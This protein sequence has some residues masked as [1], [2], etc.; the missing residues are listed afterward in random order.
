MNYP[1]FYDDV[2]SIELYDPLSEVLGTF[3]DGNYS[4]SYKEVVKSAGHSCPTVAGAYIV[5]LVGLKA[6]YKDQ[7]A[8]RG[9]IEVRF[10][11]SLE[12]G[13]A[14]VIANVITQIT[15]ATDKS[16]FKGLGGIF[17]RH[18]LMHFSS[19]IASS[20]RFTRKDTQE[21]VDLFYNPKEILPNPKM[22][23]LMQ[24]ILQQSASTQEKQEFGALWQE[25][26]ENIFFNIEKVVRVEK[27]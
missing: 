13:V 23:P 25:R 19:D 11:E 27:V 20:V 17:A 18:S 5:T 21:S 4:I 15:G 10:K 22:Q 9:E 26:V 12:E 6:L 2:E 3:E 8:V 16:G 14:G 1:K 24:K 7:K